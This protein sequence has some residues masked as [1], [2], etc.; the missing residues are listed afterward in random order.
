MRSTR[1]DSGSIIVSILVIMIFLTITILSLAVISQTN[2][3]RANQ[4][5][6]LLQAQYAAESGADVV[7]AYLN[8]STEAYADSGVE[9]KL[10]KD[11]FATNYRATYQ[12]TVTNTASPN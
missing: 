8:S 12:A 3:S 5:I 1:S 11:A 2:I 7:V 4:R 6:L 10:F 9:K